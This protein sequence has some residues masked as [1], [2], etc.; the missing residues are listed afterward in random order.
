[1][2]YAALIAL[3]WL[4]GCAGD[5]VYRPVDVSM[6]LAAPCK[7]PRI[8]EPSWPLKKTDADAPLF[9]KTKKALA[10]IELRKAYEAELRAALTA[11][12]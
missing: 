1:M 8:D 10:E 7:A 6:P 2:R 4:A 3:A 9:D 12:Q 5:P 11:C